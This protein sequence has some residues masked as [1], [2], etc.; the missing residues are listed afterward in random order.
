MKKLRKKGG[1]SGRELGKKKWE[2]PSNSSG[3]KGGQGK[4]DWKSRE[5]NVKEIDEKSS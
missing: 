5:F 3:G 2:I 4:I 1:F